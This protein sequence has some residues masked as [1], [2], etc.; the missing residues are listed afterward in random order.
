M[1]N[2]PT[3]NVPAAVTKTDHR[4]ILKR[5]GWIKISCQQL[6]QSIRIDVTPNFKCGIFFTNTWNRF[7]LFWWFRG[8]QPH[9]Q[10][11]YHLTQQ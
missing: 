3:T 11:D 5:L 8:P 2:N 4:P 9:S 1:L 6:S 7:L 10:G